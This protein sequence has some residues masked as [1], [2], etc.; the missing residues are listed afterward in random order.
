MCCV[1][2]ACLAVIYTE[3]L[4]NRT[5]LV[6]DQRILVILKRSRS[7][8]VLHNVTQRRMHSP[9]NLMTFQ[10]MYHLRMSSEKKSFI[11]LIVQSD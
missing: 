4:Q 5:D 6:E 8:F 2:G 11:L 9:Q 1:T 10:L 7:M 3:K